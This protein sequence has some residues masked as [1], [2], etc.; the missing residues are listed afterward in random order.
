MFTCDKFWIVVLVDHAVGPTEKSEAY[1]DENSENPGFI[2]SGLKRTKAL[3]H[4][5]L[6]EI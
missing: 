2:F 5:I 3:K 4:E 6:Y 1:Q